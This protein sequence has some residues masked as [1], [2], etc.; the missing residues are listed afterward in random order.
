M[1]DVSVL[2][3]TNCIISPTA[4]NKADGKARRNQ[5]SSAKLLAGVSQYTTM[6]L[7]LQCGFNTSVWGLLQF[8]NNIAVFQLLNISH[9]NL[10]SKGRE[11]EEEKS[12]NWDTATAKQRSSEKICGGR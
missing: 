2:V 5:A 8:K 9:N 6:A 12:S 3:Q 1:Y 10:F 11:E 7:I 4:V